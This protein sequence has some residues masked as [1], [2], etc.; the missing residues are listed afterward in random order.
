MGL[1]SAPAARKVSC[2][3]VDSRN[4]AAS[5]S[6]ICGTSISAT[7]GSPSVDNTF[8]RPSDKACT[9][10]LEKAHTSATA[11]AVNLALL[12]GFGMVC[13]VDMMDSVV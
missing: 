5:A 6:V 11:I 9:D 1:N 4:E 13:I 12:R 3:A 10:E 2:E 7:N 8:S